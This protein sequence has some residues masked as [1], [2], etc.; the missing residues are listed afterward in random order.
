MHRQVKENR[1]SKL[2]VRFENF[3]HKQT[4]IKCVCRKNVENT[5]G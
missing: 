3:A 2:A 4:N 1:A 5:H